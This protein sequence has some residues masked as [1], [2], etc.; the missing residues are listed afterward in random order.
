MKATRFLIAILGLALMTTLGR[1]AGD[2]GP[3]GG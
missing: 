3:L 1:S 2:K